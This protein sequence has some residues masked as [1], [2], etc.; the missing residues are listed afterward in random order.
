MHSY[1]LEILTSEQNWTCLHLVGHCDL[2]L[3]WV[4]FIFTILDTKVSLTFYANIIPIG[5][6][7]VDFFHV[8]SNG[9]DLVIST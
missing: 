1:F 4:V 6:E 5:F 2:I 3:L 8:F 9:G 7:E